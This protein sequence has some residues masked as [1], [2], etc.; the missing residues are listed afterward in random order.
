MKY[1]NIAIKC[2]KEDAET[3]QKHL[4][5]LKYY[6]IDNGTKH[7]HLKY[8][9]HKFMSEHI[10]FIIKNDTSIHYTNYNPTN[11]K[12]NEDLE[13]IDYLKL[14]RREKLKRLK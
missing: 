10:Y 11:F 8:F 14:I 7:R 12:N 3:V 5:K 2:R 4:F 1:K 9:N 13:L 6:W